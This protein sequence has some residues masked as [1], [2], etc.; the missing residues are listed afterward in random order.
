M[1][2]PFTIPDMTRDT[3][4][5]STEPDFGSLNGSVLSDTATA[6]AQFSLLDPSGHEEQLLELLAE[7][8]E[9]KSLCEKGLHSIP[10]ECLEPKF[11][12]ILRLRASDLRLEV[13]TFLEH[14]TCPFVERRS[15]RIAA[16]II[17]STL[18]IELKELDA[19]LQELAS[20]K[21]HTLEQRLQR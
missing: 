11:A 6:S 8:Q 20:A 5:Y 7:D 12:H 17:A 19:E 1:K 15:F 16:R 10:V 4:M 2:R 13:R 14:K 9:L 18:S 3:D 21:E